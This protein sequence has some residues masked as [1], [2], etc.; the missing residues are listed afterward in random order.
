MCFKEEICLWEC[1][2]GQGLDPRNICRCIDDAEIDAIWLNC[3][4]PFEDFCDGKPPE[5]PVC[6]KTCEGNF[7][8]NEDDCVCECDITCPMGMVKDEATCECVPEMMCMVDCQGMATANPV[9]C[10]CE[11]D[12]TCPAG[13]VKDEATCECVEEPTCLL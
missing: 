10:E 1:P 7:T 4:I 13:M 3:I 2:Y 8:L 12:I 6:D 5:P 11:C 9:T